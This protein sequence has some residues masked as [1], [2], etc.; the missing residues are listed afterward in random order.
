MQDWF[1]FLYQRKDEFTLLLSCA[2]GTKYSGFI[3][4]LVERMADGTYAYLLELQRRGMVD[5]PISKQ[6]LQVLLTA[7]WDMIREPFLLHFDK[8]ELDAHCRL[9][10]Q[11]F[12]WQH[13]LG[14]HMPG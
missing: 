6:E 9:C 14:L 8:D 3:P 12:H 7:F 2:E 10:C 1:D 13:I 5:H 11:M 4:Q